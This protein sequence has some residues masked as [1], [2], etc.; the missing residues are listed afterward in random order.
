MLQAG[1]NIVLAEETGKKYSMHTIMPQ[2]TVFPL[3]YLYYRVPTVGASPL[4]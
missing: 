2:Y 3:G 4:A 1:N